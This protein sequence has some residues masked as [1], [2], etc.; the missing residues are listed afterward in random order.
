MMK[1]L[2]N[3]PLYLQ[4]RDA[5]VQRIAGGDWR[6]GAAIANEVDLAAEFGVSPGTMRKALDLMEA[7]RLLTRKQGRGT[8]VNDPASDE[9]VVRFSNIRNA[10]GDRITGDIK[11]ETIAQ[12][13]AT[14]REI[15]R[16]RLERQDE[17]YRVRRSRSH[18]GRTYMVED[19]ALP[20][21]LFPGLL[22]QPALADRI[23][24]LARHYGVLLARSQ[25]R[26]SVSAP[27]RDVTNALGRPAGA[28]IL[29]LDRVV[30]ALDGRPIEWR[31]G[32]CHLADEQYVA[33]MT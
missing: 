8:F 17:V 12:V 22:Q 29:G 10:S 21:A 28:S 30:F 26:V 14:D 11:V 4:L 18:N 7:E 25:E 33:E 13:P 3:R 5:L 15:E 20:A 2:V 27:E 1:P 24:V 6:P 9:L 19:A 32:Y 31:V 16:L 23:V